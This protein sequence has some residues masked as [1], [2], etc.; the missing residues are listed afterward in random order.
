VSFLTLQGVVN[1]K[2]PVLYL[3]TTRTDWRRGDQ[4]H[5]EILRKDHGIRFRAIRSRRS[6]YEKLRSRIKGAVVY[7]PDLD[8]SRWIAVTLSG[9][10]GLIPLMPEQVEEIPWD[11]EVKHD[12]RGRWKDVHSAYEW[13]IR[14]LLPR[15]DPKIAFS[16]GYSYDD[17]D[18][19][20][21][22]GVIISLDHVVSRNGFVFNLSPAGKPDKY[23]DGPVQGYPDDLRLFKRILKKM[24]APAA[25][26]GWAEPEWTYA[27]LLSRFNH[28]V[29]C[30]VSSN[31]SFHS[32]IKKVSKGRLRQ[33]KP[34]ERPKLE[35]KCYLALMTSEGDAPRVVSSFFGGA[36]LSR[37]R[38]SL[39]INWGLSPLL[40][41]EVPALMDYFYRTAT[42][43]DFFY[44]GVG[45]AGYCFVNLLTDVKQFAEHGKPHFR[46]ADMKIM[47]VWQNG[48]V[49]YK[50]YERYT[51]ICGL[52]GIAHLAKGPAD[53]RILPNGVPIVF[54][55]HQLVH[56]KKD[57][58]KKTARIIR[59]I[60]KDRDLPQFIL[61][62][63]SPGER[64]LERYQAILDEL[65]PEV[66]EPIRLDVMVEL[67]KKARK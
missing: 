7:D 67:V 6:L 1:Q 26:W 46:K 28:Y 66:F 30:G 19:G 12:L 34:F 40:A 5:R 8:A 62:Y 47:E 16:A 52:R 50:K 55:D 43:N 60:V 38:G 17:V 59:K 58:P 24:E 10:E 51:D 33:T 64:V 57:V 31:F 21:D 15:C 37:K 65:D 42:E 18:I 49:A 56:Y 41:A 61:L 2:G 36:W 39:P 45:G 48:S 25:F 35:K 53:V 27:S 44:A 32:H 13:A 20:H 22:L 3:D 11:I 23:P 63:T 9:L 14:E 29:M 4:K 54:M